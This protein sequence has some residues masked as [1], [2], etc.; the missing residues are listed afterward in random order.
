M[1][2]KS[3]YSMSDMTQDRVPCFRLSARR[4]SS[5]CACFLASNQHSVLINL[6]MKLVS[7]I[8]GLN[9]TFVRP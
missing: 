7:A 2:A 8:I 9:C 1:E 5:C 4:S 6:N 3:D